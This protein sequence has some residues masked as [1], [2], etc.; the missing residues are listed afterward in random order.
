MKMKGFVLALAA[1][2]CLGAM[3][4]TA[5]AAERVEE[6]YISLVSDSDIYSLTP[7]DTVSKKDPTTPDGGG[8]YWI[9]KNTFSGSGE[10]P[11]SYYTYVMELQCAD[12]YRFDSNTEV[13]VYG[14]FEISVNVKSSRSMTVRAK[15]YP[16]YRLNEVSGISLDLEGG[17][18]DWSKVDHASSY[19]VKIYYTDRNGVE[20]TTKRTSKP[21]NMSISGYKK[22]ADY[23]DVHVSIKALKG[24]STGDRFI[25]ESNYAME[26]GGT[27][28]QEDVDVYN[29]RIP[30]ATRNG[31]R[32]DYYVPGS[33]SPSGTFSNSTGYTGWQGSGN[34]WYY[35]VNGVRSI[36]WVQPS[37][38]EWYLLDNNGLML[39]GWQTVGGLQYYMNTV[40]NGSYGKMLVGLQNIN[41]IYYYF[42]EQHDGTYGAMYIN[43]YIPD[44]RY[45]G[46]NGMITGGPQT[47][48]GSIHVGT[49]NGPGAVSGGVIPQ[50]YDQ[51]GPGV[52]GS[53][54]SGYSG[55]TGGGN[56]WYYTIG[57]I[58]STGWIEPSAGEWY[59]L[60]DNGVM[61][62]GL[63]RAG[64]YYYYLNP[65]H[66]GSFG[67]MLT[68]Y[69]NI[70][71]RN[72]YFNEQH[73]GTYGAMYMNR[74][75]P[76]GRYAG[77]NGVLY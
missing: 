11:G 38:G 35:L 53:S 15:T 75:S 25:M 40:H 68:G 39:T 7:G 46:S 42:N 17:K 55:W 37:D 10:N 54:G 22:Y 36:G 52:S 9:E 20:R 31:V 73:D 48:S 8:E 74:Y 12:G 67:K 14:A 47:N 1:C 62:Y 29:F 61:L 70:S 3:S 26:S 50:V 23:G 33:P 18:L 56:V 49:T 57:G 28:P 21:V 60:N 59:L 13:V 58:R 77:A 51:S 43:K 69:Q 65:S 6:V 2:I 41:G 45:A 19:S 24:S 76:D 5:F 32:D 30:T 63:Q 66:D 34:T 4:V 64:S 44:G 72:Y 27:D 16:F 71:G